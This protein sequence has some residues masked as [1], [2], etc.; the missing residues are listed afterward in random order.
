MAPSTATSLQKRKRTESDT[1]NSK[2]P[3]RPPKKEPKK[4]RDWVRDIKQYMEEMRKWYTKDPKKKAWPLRCKPEAILMEM[5]RSPRNEKRSNHRTIRWINDVANRGKDHPP[6]SV[7]NWRHFQWKFP[8]PEAL[9]AACILESGSPTLTRVQNTLG[10]LD[11]EWILNPD[12][13]PSA[14]WNGFNIASQAEAVTNMIERKPNFSLKCPFEVNNM[15]AYMAGETNKVGPVLLAKVVVD[16]KE[17][18]LP[19]MGL[20][21]ISATGS[22]QCSTPYLPPCLSILTSYLTFSMGTFIKNDQ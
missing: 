4:E 3:Q 16:G 2:K 6:A 9:I 7:E 12:R 10:M 15:A 14:W 19:V 17:R 21:N 5:M 13:K 11:G 8:T 18:R 22:I 20:R 1:G